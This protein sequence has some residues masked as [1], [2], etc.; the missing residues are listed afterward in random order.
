MPVGALVAPIMAA[1]G[2]VTLEGLAIGASIVGTGMQ[3]VGA[4]TGSKTLQKIGTGFSMAGGVG[5]A[6]GGI[7]SLMSPASVTGTASKSSGLLQTDNIDDMLKAPTKGT[8]DLQG[9]KTFGTSGAERSS[10][11][12]FNSNSKLIG[13]GSNSA[14]FDPEL[15]KSF[16]RRAGDTL[17]TPYNPLMNIMGGM[18][19]AYMMNA[20]MEQRSDMQ[21]KQLAFDQ[22]LVDRTRVNNGTLLNIDPALNITR[23]N[24]AYAPL[25][26]G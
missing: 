14:G 6:A 2:A 20:Q 19:E 11:D 13:S 10:I 12:S 17:L 21:D 22:Q 8:K 9:L 3:A 18:G 15:E 7:K 16:F 26:R 5:L 1:A 23:N 4:I 24:N 25:L